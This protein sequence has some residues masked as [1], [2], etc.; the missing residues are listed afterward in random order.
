[1]TNL[2]ALVA[3]VEPY[4][5][6]ELAYTKKLTDAGLDNSAIYVTENRLEIA[7]CAISILVSLLPL[8]SDSTGKSSQ[9]YNR[10]GLE[11]HIKTLCKNNGLNIDDYLEVPSVTVFHNMF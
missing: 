7:K 5:V 3:E 4:T 8:S 1:M 9:S 2:E 6:S 11:K 10:D